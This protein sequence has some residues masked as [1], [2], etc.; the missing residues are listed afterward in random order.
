MTCDCKTKESACPISS[1][2]DVDADDNNASRTLTHGGSTFFVA[3]GACS[4]IQ[5][6]GSGAGPKMTPSSAVGAARVRERVWV[7]KW[8]R[9]IFKVTTVPLRA[10][11][12]AR[13]PNS[14]AAQ[15]RVS[16]S[17]SVCTTSSV[18]AVS[19]GFESCSAAGWTGRRRSCSTADGSACRCAQASAQ[20]LQR[21][22]A[23]VA[24]LFVSP[25]ARVVGPSGCRRQGAA[26]A[27]RGDRV[28]RR[29]HRRR[30]DRR[31]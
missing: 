13:S 12:P 8:C 14:Y 9:R 31:A 21:L 10:S 7:S 1:H 19:L 23:H 29:R 11:C 4:D 22:G 2:H 27:R 24:R 16:R 17:T 30:R 5:G 3:A 20:I 26:P 25:P 18:K 28:A 6:H 15:R